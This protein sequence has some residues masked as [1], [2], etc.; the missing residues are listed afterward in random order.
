MSTNANVAPATNTRF[1]RMNT[2]RRNYTPLGEPIESALKKLKQTNM[3]TF[4]E[5]RVFGLGPFKPNWWNDN[6]F[7]EYHRTKVHKT[8]SCYNLKNLIQ[9]LIDQGDITMDTKKG[10]TN[11]NHTIFKDPFV[12]RDKGKASTSGTQDNMAIYTS[13]V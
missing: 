7:C 2:P 5:I 11:T 1:P 4:Q 3:I 13:L 8:T 9:D 12:K 10:S 6:E